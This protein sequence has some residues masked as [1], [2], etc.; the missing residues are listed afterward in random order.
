MQIISVAGDRFSWRMP[1]EVSGVM[2]AA[3]IAVL[4]TTGPEELQGLEQELVD[5]VFFAIVRRSFP[6]RTAACLTPPPAIPAD[7]PVRDRLRRRG[8]ARCS[9]PRARVRSPPAVPVLIPRRLFTRGR[10]ERT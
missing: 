8:A 9:V 5:E 4:D 6:W 3:E 10:K 7:R 1:K 2:I